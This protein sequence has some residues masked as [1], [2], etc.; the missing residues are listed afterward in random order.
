[1]I[2]FVQLIKLQS[3]FGN[4]ERFKLDERF[5]EDEDFNGN[6]DEEISKEETSITD[7]KDEKEWQLNILQE[8]LRKPIRTTEPSDHKTIKKFVKCNFFNFD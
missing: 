1:M 7:L 3:R 6:R 5:L 8:V 4:D 2:S